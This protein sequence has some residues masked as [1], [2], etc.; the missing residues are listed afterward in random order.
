[1][2]G[3]QRVV[4]FVRALAL[5]AAAITSM[6]AASGQTPDLPE[7]LAPWRDWVLYGEEFR[8]CPVRN[9]RAPGEVASHVCGWP[10]LLSLDVRAGGA[11]FAQTWTLYAEEWVPL[12]GDGERWPA[13]VE[14]D[15][16]A[17][18]VVARDGRPA[19]RLGAGTHRVEG[20]IAFAA[21]PA[22]IAIPPATALVALTLDGE[23]VARPEIDRGT[24]WLGIRPDAEVEED[25]LD[26]IVH[27]LLSDTLPM[28]LETRITLD[29]AGQSREAVLAG[30]AVAGFTG[31]RLEAGLPA[32]LTPEGLLRVQVRPGQWEIVL[33]ARSPAPA[34][35]VARGEAVGAWPADEIWSFM[36][37]PR[38]RVAALEG[39][40]ALDSRR[41]GVPPEWQ[42][43]PSYRIPAE[44]TVA[45][46]ERSRNDAAQPNRLT[47]RRDLWLDFGGGGATARD[48][49]GGQMWSEW[50]LDMAPPYTMTMASIDDEN[51]LVT[52]GAEPG[53]QGV[54]V[55]AH[56]LE[57]TTTARLPGAGSLPVT[58]YRERFDDVS[59]TVHLPPG[60]RLLAA[61]GADFAAG[62]WIER[63]RLLDVFLVLIVTAAAWRLFGAAAGVAALLGLVLTFHEPGAPRWAWLN[64]LVAIALVRAAPPGRLETFAR[65][66]RWLSL[67]AVV[68]LLIPFAATE[69][70]TA[71]FPQ[72]ERAMLARD[73]DTEDFVGTSFGI[74]EATEFQMRTRSLDIDEIVVT[75]SRRIDDGLARYQ[76]GAL[77]QTGPGLPDWMWT[78]H[79]LRFDGPVEAEQAF[80]LVTIGPTLVATWRIASVLLALALLWLLAGRPG[81]V[82]PGL[83]RGAPA[84][85][86]LLALAAVAPSQSVHAQAASEFPSPTLLEELK[87]RLTAPAPCHPACAEA[88]NAVVELD[89]GTLTIEVTFALAA[90]VA[91]PVP[92][93]TRAWRPAEI[94]VDGTAVNALFRDA[95][96]T[97]WLALPAGV[98][99]VVLRGP[100]PPG[101][102]VT[103]PFPLQPR[104]IEV[105]APGWNV[106]G[107]G[108]GRLQ[109]GT[110][111][112]TREQEAE[113]SEIGGTVFPPYVSVVRRI[114]FDIDWRVTTSVMRV[115]PDRGAF[116]L[117]IGLLPN[118]A[119]LTPGIEVAGGRATAAFAEGEEA[120]EWASRLPTAETLTLTAPDDAPWSERWVLSVGEIWHAEAAGLPSTMPAFLDAVPYTLE[121]YPRPGESLTVALTR[122]EPA[123]GDT[124]AIDSVNYHR[125]AGARSALSTLELDYRSTR[126][127]Q[128]VLTLPEGSVL[129]SVAIDGDPVPLNLD[130]RQLGIPVTPGEHYVDISWR[131]PVE[132]GLL[133]RVPEV[134]LGGGAS[135]IETI[136]TLPA[137]RWVLATTGPR[138]GPAILYWPE[139]LA[140]VIAAVALGRLALSP[141]RT[142]EWL[143]L[144]LGLSTFAWPVLALFAAW[145]FALA[146]R[147][148]GRPQLSRRRFNAL[149]VLLGLLTVGAL[150]A[151][152]SAIPLGLLG[153]P[154]MH[155]VSPVQRGELSWF[156]DRTAGTTP[157]AGVFSVSLWFYKAA[158][159]GWALWLCFALLRWLPWAWRAFGRDGFW[160]RRAPAPAV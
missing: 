74:P 130:G 144:G 87:S 125:E 83:I 90:P 28:R 16:D 143:L 64:L 25:R 76:P 46:V 70:R 118:E 34:A 111:E 47:L 24:L 154:D 30:A 65:R 134:D 116:T 138:V 1:M 52:Q 139:L 69:L 17:F 128:H 71:L 81:R 140:L 117:P 33:H 92:S 151:L 93:V 22:S 10:G 109:S 77:V 104:R 61:P 42:D 4:S 155:I 91:V 78:Q 156:V 2:H 73:V 57:L 20:E 153:Q 94:R 9:G 150:A 86:A 129:E 98:H 95:A 122:P 145:A 7:P 60:Y 158:M 105:T 152:I 68:L 106:A 147:G 6:Q 112:L 131:E 15:G 51:L 44:Q 100:A 108:N 53:V 142:H 5:L 36:P 32:Q 85:A 55:R 141:L 12:P 35:T 119:V 82:P 101:N 58:G 103:L 146:W 59:T 157:A 88:S 126:G 135:N 13:V 50:R 133:S 123:S 40:E 8:A 11:R 107:V 27:R 29:V 38:L 49:V 45:I 3:R 54:E 137:D 124:I 120:V 14:V 18:P 132:L 102:S 96:Q 21:R 160:E 115:A 99:A 63:W 39:A 110:L 113:G 26:V 75:G 19:V 84:A 121:Y 31:E 148:R 67:A 127:D 80:R 23:T 89:G 43:L 56:R 149:Q 72:L 79:R 97:A 136:L 48:R 62:V 159:L 114:A 66:Y 41:A 37:Q